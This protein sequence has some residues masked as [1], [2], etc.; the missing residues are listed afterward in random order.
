MSRAI[1]YVLIV[2]VAILTM[3]ASECSSSKTPDTIQKEQTQQMAA[4]AQRQTG[5][6][7]ITNFTERKFVKYLYELRDREG[8]GTYTYIVDLNGGLHFVCE[9]VGFGIPYSAQY[10]NSERIWTATNG[11]GGT[12]PQP[13]PNGLFVPDGLSATWVLCSN[14]GKVQPVYVEPQILVSP[15]PM[16]AKANY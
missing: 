4:E 3:G 15:F 11:R 6:P 7:G 14:E 13:E 10:V 1:T 9:S 12:I 16:D 2:A 5:M 8:Y